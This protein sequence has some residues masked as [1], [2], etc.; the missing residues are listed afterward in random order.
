MA[1]ERPA[2][3]RLIEAQSRRIEYVGKVRF[4][5][6]FEFWLEFRSSSWSG[7]N[8]RIGIEHPAFISKI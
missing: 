5:Y 3:H 2:I 4:V 1:V 8:A 7:D 6:F